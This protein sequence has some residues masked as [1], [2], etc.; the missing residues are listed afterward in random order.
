[1]TF[2]PNRLALPSQLLMGKPEAIGS[3]A[4]LDEEFHLKQRIAGKAE[5]AGRRNRCGD[6]CPVLY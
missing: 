4:G 6:L 1:M 3:P 5:K 2:S